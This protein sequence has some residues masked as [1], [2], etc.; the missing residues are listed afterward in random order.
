MASSAARDLA[1]AIYMI[2]TGG[3]NL[4]R[5]EH[6]SHT[7]RK[8]VDE[9]ADLID[10]FPPLVKMRHRAMIAGCGSPGNPGCEPCR[11]L[12]AALAPWLDGKETP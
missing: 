7:E 1:L 5:Y 12:Y 9:I 2:G 11:K 6:L 10:A 3:W 8:K 4:L